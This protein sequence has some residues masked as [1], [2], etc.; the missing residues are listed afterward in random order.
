MD[1]NRLETLVYAAKKAAG[2]SIATVTNVGKALPVNV[3]ASQ[4]QICAAAKVHVLLH[5]H[6]DL[7]V[8]QR[9]VVLH[10]TRMNNDMIRQQG[11]NTGMRKHNG[12]VEEL[13]AIFLL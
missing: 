3:A 10:K 5:L 11:D 8:V 12:F 2:G 1:D 13:C 6:C 7:L 9:R 4:Q